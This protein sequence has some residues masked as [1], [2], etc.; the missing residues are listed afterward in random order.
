MPDKVSTVIQAFEKPAGRVC[1]ETV[2]KFDQVGAGT[3]IMASVCELP[4]KISPN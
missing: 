2:W 1:V 4:A 3:N